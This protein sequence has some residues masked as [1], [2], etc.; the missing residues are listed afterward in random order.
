MSRI[1]LAIALFLLALMDPKGMAIMFVAYKK[2]KAPLDPIRSGVIPTEFEC[3][4]DQKK[5][6]RVGVAD[7]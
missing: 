3:R 1:K 6:S 4:T 5:H 7:A 2:S